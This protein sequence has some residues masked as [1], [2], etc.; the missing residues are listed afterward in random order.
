ALLDVEEA[1]ADGHR[2]LVPKLRVADA[3]AVDQDVGHERILTAR[4][5]RPASWDCPWHMSVR[6]ANGAVHRL[7]RVNDALQRAQLLMA[8][9]DDELRKELPE[10]ADIFDAHTPRRTHT[11][12]MAGLYDDLERGMYK[13]GISRWYVNCLDENDPH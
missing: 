11:D 6:G 1:V 2:H 13:Y 8:Q 4:L 3:V 5:L 7:R 10:G 9:W 12:G